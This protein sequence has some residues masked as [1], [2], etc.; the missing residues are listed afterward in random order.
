MNLK[1]L[2][3]N[4]HV[5]IAARCENIRSAEDPT[6]AHIIGT[7]ANF[8]NLR[9][10][11]ELIPGTVPGSSKLQ[12][13]FLGGQIGEWGMR[14]CSTPEF[15]R[16]TTYLMFLL[17]DGTQYAT[18]LVG[19]HQGQFRI[20]YDAA[21]GEAYLL[22]TSGHALLAIE[23][24]E[25]SFTELPVARI[26]NGIAEFEPSRN[27]LKVT[28]TNGRQHAAPM[29]LELFIDAIENTDFEYPT[30]LDFRGG[31]MPTASLPLDTTN[32]WNALNFSS[33][34]GTLGACMHQ[35]VY[36]WFE[37]NDGMPGYSSSWS[38]IED[39]AKAL[40]D[41]HMNIFSDTPNPTD[42]YYPGNG[43]CEVAGWLTNSQSS[44]IYGYSWGPSTLA[45]CVYWYSGSEIVEADI[46]M[47]AAFSWT[48]D[49]NNAF[50]SN[51]INYRNVILHEFGHAWGYQVGSCHTETYDYGQPSVMH[52]YYY[53]LWEDGHEIHAQD[54]KTIRDLYDGQATVKDVDDLGV[55]SYRA[56]SG[57]GLVNGYCS[58]PSIP[59][60]QVFTVYNVTIE[61]CSDDSQ[62]GVRARFYLSTNRTLTS[63]D[64][65]VGNH[66]IG[67]MG[68][69]TIDIGSY[70]LDTDGV[71]AGVY[72]IGMKVS[73]GG[74][75]YSADDRQAND[76]AWSTY[77]VHVTAGATGITENAPSTLLV[78]PNPVENMV[79]V[80]WPEEVSEGSVMIQDLSGRS[81]LE[82]IHASPVAGHLQLDVSGQA[83]ATYLLTLTST[84]G[85][86]F[87][88]RVIK[89]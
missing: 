55:E 43:E 2:V 51:A 11:R 6:R 50:D 13:H 39:Y 78:Y 62:S 38:G 27:P 89:R 10:V 1:D 37:Q 12:I 29:P 79:S 49:W 34:R 83:A 57:T 8:G 20:V 40:Y 61:N 28:G 4:S 18:P 81:V 17:H 65:L 44:S 64:H 36:I 15:E 42:G 19:G 52:Q 77:T 58:N 24:S 3:S 26:T 56:T 32:S 73:R 60:G 53:S 33:P 72:Y 23:R 54:A 14:T 45:R 67:T 5:I 7:T 66:D 71:P 86:R 88:A 31:G 22:S 59:S 70:T 68:A 9:V 75:A 82:Q 21:N 16:G 74:T 41:V 25:L 87:V 47:N 85:R 30:L 63:S 84:D 48:S 69:E 46:M 80:A 35:E 76:L